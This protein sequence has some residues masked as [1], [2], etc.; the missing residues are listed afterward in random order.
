M[1]TTAAAGAKPKRT[2]I[3]AAAGVLAAV[4]FGVFLMPLPGGGDPITSAVISSTLGV[5]ALLGDLFHMRLNVRA[6]VIGS[7]WTFPGRAMLKL[8]APLMWAV[9]VLYH[10]VAWLSASMAWVGQ[11]LQS[12]VPPEAPGCAQSQQPLVTGSCLLL[13]DR[14]VEP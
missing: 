4:L 8:M 1:P 9:V 14:R 12:H 13:Q 10:R 11:H 5:A 7:I 3:G 6:V 2:L